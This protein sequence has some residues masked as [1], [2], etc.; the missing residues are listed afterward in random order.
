M[1]EGPDI[2]LRFENMSSQRYYEVHVQRDLFNLWSVTRVWGRKNSALG[3]IR[4][5][6]CDSYLHAIHEVDTIIQQRRNRGYQLK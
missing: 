6:A 3:Q 1:H 2:R 5:Q 4:H